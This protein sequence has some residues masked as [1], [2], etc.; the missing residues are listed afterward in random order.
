MK[1][2][3]LS[4]SAR[5]QADE[6]L[7]L[8]GIAD[9]NELAHIALHIG[10]EIIAIHARWLQ[11]HMVQT[12]IKTLEQQAV[13]IGKVMVG[14]YFHAVEGKQR[15]HSRPSGQRLTDGC[16]DM[17]LLAAGQNKTSRRGVFIN[18]RL[19]VRGEFRHALDF[20]ENRAVGNRGE[21][22]TRIIGREL[23]DIRRFEVE[24]WFVWKRA[25]AESRFCRFAWVQSA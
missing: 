5:A 10:F 17:Q 20:I 9:I 15:E 24:V 1:V 16:M 21:K 11:P 22:S 25:S 2:E 14:T 19:Q 7:K 23:T 12:R 3:Q 13:H 8:S 4:G 6:S 18:K